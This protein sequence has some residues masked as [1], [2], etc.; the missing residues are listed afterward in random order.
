[1]RMGWDGLRGRLKA[2]VTQKDSADRRG[3]WLQ[4]GLPG[5]LLLVLLVVTL[6]VGARASNQ[7]ALAAGQSWTQ[8]MYDNGRSDFNPLETAITQATAPNL[9]LK[10]HQ[11]IGQHKIFTQPVVG[12]G[13]IYYGA[14]DGY[15]HATD[16]SGN[17][18]WRTNIGNV[19][20]SCT[21]K[22]NG[23]TSTATLVT[24][25]VSGIAT[26]ALL[27]G[28]GD[29]QLYALNAATGAIIWQ[30]VLGPKASDF[31]WDSPAVYNSSVYLGVAGY[32]DCRGAI[33]QGAY[34]KL[35]LQ[36]G[37][38]Q[39]TF[40]TV[41]T[42]CTGSGVW[43]STAIDDE[44]GILYFATANGGSCSTTETLAQAMVAVRASDLT[45]LG[46]WQIKQQSSADLDWGTTPTLFNATYGGTRHLLV[47]LASKNG[48]YYAFDR[49]NITA[50]PVW[51][52]KIAVGGSSPADGSISSSAWDGSHIYAAGGKTTING[53]VCV[54]SV[55]ALDP[56]TGA[57]VWQKCLTTGPV[58]GSVM[59]VPGLIVL[60]AGSNLDVIASTGSK[61]GTI[62]FTYNDNVSGSAFKAAPSL[63][64][65]MLY[66][67]NWDG[68]FDAFG[69]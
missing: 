64:N 66:Y 37:Q 21:N 11:R 16:L 34:F 4:Q 8:Y 52:T 38:I 58:I 43:G 51:H 59:A 69:L 10:W 12:N 56:A 23:V 62:L 19:T 55:R 1:M 7:Q 6:L 44:T 25:T 49:G 60:G 54:G 9:T 48:N 67:P 36:T 20:S 39:D 41:P 31:I 42:G 15:E 40:Y 29:A 45:V 53:T 65:G 18:Q 3:M 27:V 30:T 35:D 68:N 33:I 13:L 22:V 14:F 63:V 28:G 2:T 5:A 17:E 26:P 24:L 57:I 47:G 46:S 32:G 50:G 61:A